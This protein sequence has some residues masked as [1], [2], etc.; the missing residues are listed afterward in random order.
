MK[1]YKGKVVINKH[2]TDR[3]RYVRFE[4]VNPVEMDFLPGQYYTLLLERG[5]HRAYS[6]ASS[7]DNKTFIDT[8]VDITPNGVGAQFFIN[9][10]IGDEITYA[11]PMGKFI[12][13]HHTKP[14]IFVCTGTGITPFFSMIDFALKQQSTRQIKLL[15]GIRTVNDIFEKD[16]LNEWV[17]NYSNFSYDYCISDLQDPDHKFGMVTKFLPEEILKFNNDCEV[18]ICGRKEM[19]IDVENIALSMGIKQEDIKYE[20]FY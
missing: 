17:K 1:R 4:H 13:S 20:K 12:Y 7:V 5:A 15:H 14:V 10:Q 16:K 9:A 8:F 3:V 2:V 11:A 18:Y 19:I 6:I